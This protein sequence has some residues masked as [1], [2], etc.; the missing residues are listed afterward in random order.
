MT[1]I[2][3]GMI[4]RSIKFYC[5]VGGKKRT[6]PQ[7][8]R[9]LFKTLGLGRSDSRAV[10]ACAWNAGMRPG[11]PSLILST[12]YGTW[13]VPEWRDSPEHCWMWPPKQNQTMEIGFSLWFVWICFSKGAGLGRWLK[14]LVCYTRRS[15]SF[16]P[17]HCMVPQVLHSVPCQNINKNR[18]SL[19][20]KIPF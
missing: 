16:N 18:I 1:L 6:I 10:R 4:T 5:E 3:H 9:T 2:K 17:H 19:Q 11:Q 20:S 8:Q 12:P 7:P 14:G 13:I 15:P